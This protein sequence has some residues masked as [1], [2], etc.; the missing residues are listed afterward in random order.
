[1]ITPKRVYQIKGG[2]QTVYFVPSEIAKV[3]VIG[4]K[5]PI[6]RRSCTL[7]EYTACR[8]TGAV[9]TPCIVVIWFQQ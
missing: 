4:Q 6:R 7:Y 1:M 9:S 8:L 2:A 3:I 5:E